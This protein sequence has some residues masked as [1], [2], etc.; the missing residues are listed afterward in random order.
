[1]TDAYG[2]AAVFICQC[3]TMANMIIAVRAGKAAVR[4][5]PCCVQE[6][7]VKSLAIIQPKPTLR[8]FCVQVRLMRPLGNSA[9]AS[10]TVQRAAHL[11]RPAPEAALKLPAVIASAR[12]DSLADAPTEDQNQ[13]PRAIDNGATCT[14][15][16]HR[17]VADAPAVHADDGQRGVRYRARCVRR[18]VPQQMSSVLQRGG[19]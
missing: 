5:A 18:L 4:F 8:V 16:L 2:H 12:I 15:E 19:C 14:L 10:D 1:M 11:I 3:H 13:P 6:H 7:S 17:K 9:A